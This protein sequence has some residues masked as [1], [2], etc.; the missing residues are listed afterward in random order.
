MCVVWWWKVLLGMTQALGSVGCFR[1]IRQRGGNSRRFVVSSRRGPP[2]RRARGMLWGAGPQ[3]DG[4]GVCCGDNRTSRGVRC[5]VCV[6]GA[7]RGRVGSRRGITRSARC[8][9]PRRS[10]AGR[11]CPPSSARR[12][13]ERGWGT[14]PPRVESL[15]EQHVLF[16]PHRVVQHAAPQARCDG[17]CGGAYGRPSGRVAAPR[18]AHRPDWPLR[19]AAPRAAATAAAAPSDE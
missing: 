7:T 1:D 18:P 3:I 5:G 9:R 19:R 2:N 4:L 13:V 17:V 12:A 10:C 8:R 11:P 16:D 14:L 6:G 15:P